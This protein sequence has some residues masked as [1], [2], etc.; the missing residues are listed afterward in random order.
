MG[1]SQFHLF[2]FFIFSLSVYLNLSFMKNNW[3][4]NN[5]TTQCPPSP[6]AL[7]IIGHAHLLTFVLHKSF[8]DLASLYGPFLL[9]RVGATSS[10]LV[11]NGTIAKE[12]FKTHDIKFSARP[13]FG[14][15]DYQIYKDS[16]F[17]TL[18]YTIYWMYLKKLLMMDLLSSQ[19]VNRFA[20]VREEEMIKMLEVF[21]NHSLRGESCDLII[22]LMAFTNNLVSRL[23]M[24]KRCSV[25]DS[26][27]NEIREISKGRTLL[28]GKLSLGEV[29][30]PLKRFD[31]FG[32]GKHLKALL[33]RYD[34]LMDDI[35]LEHDLKVRFVIN[36]YAINRDPNIW[37]DAQE[38]KPERFIA[39]SV[40]NHSIHHDDEEGTKVQNFSYVPFGGG[41][42]GCPGAV[43]AAA[44]LH[45]TL[46]AMVQCFDWKIKGSEK[47]DTDD[48]AGFSAVLVHPLVCY[49]IM[50][51]NPLE[52]A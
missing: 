26:D 40:E 20:N 21:V 48:G 47:V 37:E 24:N 2:L 9:I 29:F 4:T 46:G 49:P 8:Q 32:A 38:F 52:I 27:T 18:D 16:L 19:Q 42:L 30:G 50:R 15:G 31:I 22:H 13:D 41:R 3:K 44:V 7:P 34:K 11:S 14:Y 1:R 12:V 6:P 23:T 43:L 33:L 45:R 51:V 10:Y 28:S 35:I 25:N 5:N 39:S 17:S 36:L